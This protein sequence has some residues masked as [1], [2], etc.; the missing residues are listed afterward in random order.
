MNAEGAF[1]PGKPLSSAPSASPTL[2]DPRHCLRGMTPAPTETILGGDKPP[3]QRG[4]AAGI[5]GQPKRWMVA[6][7]CYDSGGGDQLCSGHTS[8][9]TN[10][11]RDPLNA[12][13]QTPKNERAEESHPKAPRRGIDGRHVIASALTTFPCPSLAQGVVPPQSKPMEPRRAARLIKSAKGRHA[14]ARVRALPPTVCPHARPKQTACDGVQLR[15]LAHPIAPAPATPHQKTPKAPS[16][17]TP[18]DSSRQTPD[19]STYSAIPHW[20][21]SNPIRQRK[22][23]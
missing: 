9:P 1:S 18:A 21:R 3:S 19:A 11:P 10:Q 16:I 15:R 6:R 2:Y 17:T 13:K 4:D 23:L 22:S 8:K 14:I 12:G 20:K 7:L 5:R